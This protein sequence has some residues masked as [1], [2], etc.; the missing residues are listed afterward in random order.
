MVT[1]QDYVSL[2]QHRVEI[3]SE[4]TK[5]TWIVT[6]SLQSWNSTTKHQEYRISIAKETAA[7]IEQ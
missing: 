5:I 7:A 4:A 1:C 6:V 2:Q 3:R